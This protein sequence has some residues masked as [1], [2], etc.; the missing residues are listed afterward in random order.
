MTSAPAKA[1]R[2]ALG[3]L[4]LGLAAIAVLAAPVGAQ[5]LRRLHVDALS[6]RV[7]R[8]HPRVGQVFHLA[9]HVRVRENV[10]ALDELVIPDLGTL[11]SL[12]DERQVTHGPDGTDVVERLTLEP[13]LPGPFTFQPAYLDAI[14]ART[15]RPSRFSA[16]PVRIVVE[17]VPVLDTFGARLLSAIARA[18]LIVLGLVLALLVVGLGRMLRRRERT[19]VISKPPAAPPPPPT[20]RDAVAE[21]LRGYRVSPS[22]PQLFALR[23]ALFAA[24]GVSNGATLRDSLAATSDHGLR[25]ALLAAERSAFGPAYARDGASSEL[26][27]ATEAWLR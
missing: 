25:A 5:S 26:I 10:Q 7:D 11:Q 16:N 12:G 4:A 23:A 14:D 6:M 21:A 1:L 8:A 20:P 27:D 22:A 18:A 13:T 2:S 24:A 3:P 9:I 15:G 17:G 19:R